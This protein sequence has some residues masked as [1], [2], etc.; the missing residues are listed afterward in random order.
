ML[1]F[2][3]ALLM[4]AV[5]LL[6][7]VPGRADLLLSSNMTGTLQLNALPG[8]PNVYAPSVCNC[9]G[10]ANAA[11]ATVQINNGD[12]IF[13]A[14]LSPVN[15]ITADFSDTTAGD[16]LT[17]SVL[18]DSG[19]SGLAWTQTF[20]D[21]ALINFTMSQVSSTFATGSLTFAPK[22]LGSDTL[23][24]SW[25][26]SGVAQGGNQTFTATF[27]LTDPPLP[28]PSSVVSMGIELGVIG[29]IVFCRRWVK[30]AIVSKR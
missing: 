2:R 16:F 7:G 26:G 3:A 15:V 23:S 18:V 21:A 10:D 20:Q 19:R 14:N 27:S 29:L 4:A 30:P 8:I 24:F 13:G 5:V 25:S 17:L 1:K 11:S 28:E 6:A 22:A 12:T 9:T